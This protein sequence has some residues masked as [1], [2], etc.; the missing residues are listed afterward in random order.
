MHWLLPLTLVLP[1]AILMAAIRFAFMR[2]MTR[3]PG[4]AAVRDPAADVHVVEE[5]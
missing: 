4:P 3:Q 5:R 1:V 2:W